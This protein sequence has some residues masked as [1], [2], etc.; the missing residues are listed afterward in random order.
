MTGDRPTPWSRLL[1]GA[2]GLVLGTLLVG[3]VGTRITGYYA[4]VRTAASTKD[5]FST[6][7]MEL[8][9]TEAEG[10]RILIRDLSPQSFVLRR[11]ASS[12][13]ADAGPDAV[14]AEAATQAVLDE[15]QRSIDGR[16]AHNQGLLLQKRMERR[17]TSTVPAEYDAL[18]TDLKALR[19]LNS[20]TTCNDA[21]RPLAEALQRRYSWVSDRFVDALVGPRTRGEFCDDHGETFRAAATTMARELIF[22]SEVVAAHVDTASIRGLDDTRSELLSSL[23][24]DLFVI[25]LAALGLV[26]F[27]VSLVFE[28]RQ[29]AAPPERTGGPPLGGS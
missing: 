5:D 1:N 2:L 29:G 20:S 8:T 9:T 21:R 10:L 17:L 23:F 4:D 26:L 3:L 25:L 7:V 15:Q 27:L 28:H 13:P 24:T 22:Q 16:L 11:C 12:A 19:R 18:L 14:C 6:Q